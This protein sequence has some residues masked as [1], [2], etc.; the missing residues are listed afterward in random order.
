[1]TGADK[2]D[3]YLRWTGK[4]LEDLFQSGFDMVHD[5]TLE[6]LEKSRKKAEQY[7][8][9]TLSGLLADLSD[10]LNGQRHQMKKDYEMVFEVYRKL[11]QY[12]YLSRQKLEADLVKYV[13][14]QQCDGSV[15]EPAGK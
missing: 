10:R 11:N 3:E 4:I 1:M 9:Q 2:I 12:L 6:D 14:D 15:Q 5:T 8:L 13:L 7:G